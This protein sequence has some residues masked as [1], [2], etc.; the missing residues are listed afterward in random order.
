MA[1]INFK[2]EK[3]VLKQQLE[4][5]KKNN[6]KLH[7]DIIKH[8]IELSD[9]IPNS[10]Y[11]YTKIIDQIIGK[12]E[13]LDEQDFHEISNED[14]VCAKF[15]GCSFRNVKFKECRFVACVFEDCNFNGGGVVFENC[16]WYIIKRMRIDFKYK[17]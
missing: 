10:K 7:N 4:K 14:V 1:Y 6:E 2:E 12:K 8:K 11:S 17:I 9:Y 15:T 16:I 3:V 13:V 5:R